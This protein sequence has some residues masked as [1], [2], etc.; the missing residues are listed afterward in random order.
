MVF[1]A[2][3]TFTSEKAAQVAEACTK[4]YEQAGGEQAVVVAVTCAEEVRSSFL[5]SLKLL[6]SLPREADDH[7]TLLQ[8]L[9]RDR[10]PADEALCRDCQRWFVQSSSRSSALANIKPSQVLS[11]R[12]SASSSGKRATASSVRLPATAMHKRADDLSRSQVHATYPGT[13]RRSSRCSLLISLSENP[14]RNR[15]AVP[16]VCRIQRVRSRP[17]S[18]SWRT[19]T[20]KR[21][22]FRQ[23]AIIVGLLPSKKLRSVKKSEMA[24]IDR[25]SA[26]RSRSSTLLADPATDPQ[27]E[28]PPPVHLL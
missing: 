15:Q 4:W 16:Q 1:F 12:R 24:F 18:S 23:S 19:P 7:C 11:P 27:R 17:F 21:S 6:I 25:T 14:R 5:A 13:S 26:S 22:D 2:E 10:R 28:Y 3:L 9:E 8:Q 20:L